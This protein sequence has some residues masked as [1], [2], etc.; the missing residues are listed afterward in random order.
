M[1]MYRSIC[2]LIVHSN[3][4]R[5]AMWEC[6]IKLSAN[7][8]QGVRV[9]KLNPFR[10]IYIRLYNLYTLLEFCIPVIQD[11]GVALK[12]N[13]WVLFSCC[14][15]SMLCSLFSA[16]VEVLMIA[17]GHCIA[18][19][20]CCDTGTSINCQLSRYFKPTTLCSRKSLVRLP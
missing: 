20:S 19:P 9:E 4:S 3:E 13:D 14:S 12:K 15:M 18:L 7:I 16:T 10:P 8:G 6:D 5:T 11:Y 17:K 2:H 1:W